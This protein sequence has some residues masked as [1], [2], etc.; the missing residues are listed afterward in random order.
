VDNGENKS[1][2]HLFWQF[3]LE[4]V[5]RTDLKD[6]LVNM[7]SLPAK[8]VPWLQGDQILD[9][10]GDTDVQL[11]QGACLCALVDLIL[12]DRKLGLTWDIQMNHVYFMMSFLSKSARDQVMKTCKTSKED[13]PSTWLPSGKDF[14]VIAAAS[15]LCWLSSEEDVMKL[16]ARC[17][18]VWD[19]IQA[20]RRLG[21]AYLNA[22]P[23]DDMVLDTSN[24][25]IQTLYA[26]RASTI[27]INRYWKQLCDHTA[28]E[29][30]H[31]T[32]TKALKKS[33]TFF[34]TLRFPTDTMKNNRSV[35]QY[36]VDDVE[37]TSQSFYNPFLVDY[38]Q[39]P[40]Y[41]TD[42]KTNATVERK[43]FDM[44]NENALGESQ[45]TS[46]QQSNSAVFQTNGPGMAAQAGDHGTRSSKQSH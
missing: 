29:G 9:P 25:K 37:P 11:Q 15:V 19:M 8:T 1:L 18:S 24:M 27:N 35:N 16:P 2:S 36:N 40:S 39:D 30:S 28:K 10:E 22:P 32:S 6:L 14:E 33:R 4:A 13:E 23:V 42:D 26:Q 45:H 43:D 7:V 21:T 38:N 20:A 46:N 12:P 31:Q 44:H 5:E 3:Y 17:H 41:S 34:S